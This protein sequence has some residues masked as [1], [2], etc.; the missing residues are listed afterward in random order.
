MKHIKICKKKKIIYIDITDLSGKQI[1]NHTKIHIK[2]KKNETEI[3][4]YLTLKFPCKQNYL[5]YIHT[6]VNVHH[7]HI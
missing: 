6:H 3:S 2:Y 4:N 5:V 1:S 7:Q